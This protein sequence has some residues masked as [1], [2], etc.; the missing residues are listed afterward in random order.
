MFTQTIATEID[1]I[2]SRLAPVKK[3]KQKNDSHCHLNDLAIDPG[4]GC[5]VRAVGNAPPCLV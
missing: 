2:E 5:C 3:T 4:A 1:F